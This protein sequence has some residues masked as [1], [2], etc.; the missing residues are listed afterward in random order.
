MVHGLYFLSVYRIH[1]HPPHHQLYKLVSYRYSII[2]NYMTRVTHCYFIL[3]IIY[4]SYMTSMSTL[5]LLYLLS[6]IYYHMNI[7]YLYL[8]LLIL[9]LKRHIFM[10]IRCSKINIRWNYIGYRHRDHHCLLLDLFSIYHRQNWEEVFYYSW[11][12]DLKDNLT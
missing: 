8:L 4:F 10:V 9:A 12:N 3:Y 6:V 5:N 1:L 7:M 11:K 2:T